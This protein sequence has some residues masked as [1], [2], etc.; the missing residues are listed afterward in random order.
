MNNLTKTFEGQEIQIKTNKGTKLIN[1]VAT[2]KVCGLTQIK[3]GIEYIRWTDKGVANKLK[4]I[5]SH[6]CENEIKTEIQYIL[7]EIEN[8]DD[9]NS[10]YMS[11]WLS[12]RLALEC[13]SDKANRYKNFLVTLDEARENSYTAIK[14]NQ[15]DKNDVLSVAIQSMQYSMNFIQEFVK[16]SINSKDSQIDKAMELIG[17]RAVNTKQLTDK[18][19]EKLTT[20]TGTKIT[21]GHYLYIKVKSQIFKQYKVDK[22]ESIP[23]G[24]YNSVFAFIDSLEELRVN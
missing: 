18:L 16:D 7:E 14:N 2:A 17:F 22:W 8:T 12:K 15:I 23:I 19:K 21:A 24:Q 10:I 4:I 3:N 11:S 13:H 6:K 5:L 1:L 9:R 20:E